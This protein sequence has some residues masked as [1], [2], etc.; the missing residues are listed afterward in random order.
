MGL[1]RNGSLVSGGMECGV[2]SQLGSIVCED[3][4]LLQLEVRTVASSSSSSERA[5]KG[6][7]SLALLRVNGVGFIWCT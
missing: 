7:L 5:A 2:G 6:L 1:G 4:A 3:G